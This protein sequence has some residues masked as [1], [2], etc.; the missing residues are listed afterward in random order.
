MRSTAHSEKTL[1]AKYRAKRRFDET[2]EPTGS[3]RVKKKKALRFVV[4]KHDASRLHYDFR[5]EADGVLKSWAVPK[6]PSLDPADK[7]LAMQ[8]EDHPL[9]YYDFEGVIPAGNYGAGEVVVWDWG[10][11][12]TVE[13]DD[14]AR[15]IAAGKIKIRMRGEKLTGVFTLVRMHG[16]GDTDRGWLLIKERDEGADTKWRAEKHAES[17]K[18]GRTL[19]D[20]K[21]DP[22]AKKWISS[23]KTAAAK[24]APARKSAA[25][26]AKI[27]HVTHPML[28]TLIDAPFDDDAWLFEIKWDG[29]RALCTIS[30]DGAVSLMSRNGKEFLPQFPTLAKLGESFKDAP[31]VVDGEIVAL[32][33][34]GKSSFQALQNRMA[35]H[36]PRVAFVVFDVLYA[37]G[38]DLRDEPLEARKAVLERLMKK[39]SA[40]AVYSAHVV[41]EGRKLFA[42]A[43]EKGLEG[44]IAKRRD[45]K[46][47]EKRTRDWVKIKVQL[48][49]ECVIAGWTEPGGSRSDFG[50]LVL[51]VYEG[52]KLVYA[53]NVGT[54][55]SRETLGDLMKRLAPLQIDACPFATR[56]KTRTRA[57]WVKPKLVAQIRFTEWTHEGL[58]RHPAF[59]G[60]R[61]DKKAAECT[62]ERPRPAREVTR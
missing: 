18:S 13:G 27:P 17:V 40:L 36:A 10:T 20:I 19:D 54:G 62:R 24:T 55:F 23:K 33:A 38:R 32:D 7:R 28:A 21:A 16:R 59:L 2:P 48:T 1:L 35:R 8:V 50:S 49:Q 46:Y 11:Y 57:H 25:K 52:G 26:R 37:E 39:G 44:I 41:G 4:Q 47:L 61:D 29:F 9:D 30:E 14:P 58:M 6:G 3:T 53:G 12:E 31:I 60:L 42:A 51:G 34:D 56:P 22:K 5:L 43:E 15:A 45:G